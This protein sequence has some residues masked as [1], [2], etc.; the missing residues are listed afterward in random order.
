MYKYEKY[1][2]LN[3]FDEDELCFFVGDLITADMTMNAEGSAT[4]LDEGRRAWALESP[5]LDE[6][7]DGGACGIGRLQGL[8]ELLERHRRTIRG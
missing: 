6:L 5:Y 7:L 8:N 3:T 2:V 1:G 4:N